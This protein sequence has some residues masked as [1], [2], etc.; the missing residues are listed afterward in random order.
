MEEHE[1]LEL[2]RT[3][4]ERA[5]GETDRRYG[6][7]CRA[8]AFRITGSREDA[9]ECVSDALLRAWDSIPPAMPEN[10]EAFLGKL[11]RNAAIDRKR[12]NEAAKRGGGACAEVWNEMEGCLSGRNDPAE[13]MEQRELTACIEAFLLTLPAETRR[14]FLRRY[15]HFQTIG[16]IAGAMGFTETK[17]RSMLHR[18]RKKLRAYLKKR[19][20]L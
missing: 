10:L 11:T 13:R 5:I 4:D 12:Y 7:C 16:E 8:V 6:A 1:L 3:R 15:W 2:Y 18:S 19:G 14:V 9:E 17:T 20:V